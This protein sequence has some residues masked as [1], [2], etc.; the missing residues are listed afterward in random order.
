MRL[1][2]SLFALLVPALI[3]VPAI[4]ARDASTSTQREQ[5]IAALR[6]MGPPG[7][8][9]VLADSDADPDMVDAVAGQRGATDSRLFWYTNLD[10]ALAAAQETGRPVLSLRLLGKLTDEFSCANSRF[11]RTVLYSNGE[12]ADLMRDRFVL[13]WSSER[14]VPRVTIEFGDG[15]LLRRTLTGNSAHYVLDA[16]ARPIEALPGLYDP[17]TFAE[18]I[19]AAAD[20]H[21]KML[22]AGDDAAQTLVTFHAHRLQETLTAMHRDLVSLRGDAKAPSLEALRLELERPFEPEA[23]PAARRAMPL[24]VTKALTETTLLARIGGGLG[25]ESGTFSRVEYASLAAEVS[26]RVELHDASVKHVR[27]E[28]PSLDDGSLAWML[29]NLRRSVAEDTLRNEYALHTRIH[30]WFATETAPSEFERFNRR[31]YR[32][33]FLTPRE[34][35]WLGLVEPTV[36]TGLTEGGRSTKLTQ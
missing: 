6:L 12:V 32:D 30:S 16:A 13:H 14:P 25:D 21:G 2:S 3:L 23:M 10:R 20:L 8:E 4:L 34:D 36:Y 17:A 18:M 22:D 19:E 27:S 5:T 24:T 11:F 31:V 33:L 26:S 1:R 29:A 7:L 35:A 9:A 15:R 28:N